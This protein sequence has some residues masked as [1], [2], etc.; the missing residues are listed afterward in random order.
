MSYVSYCIDFADSFR[1]L[2]VDQ[3]KWSQETF[4]TDAERGP[5]GALRHLEKEAVEAQEAVG[6]PKLQEELADCFLLLLDAN[7]RAG[8]RPW[9]LMK[10]AHAKMIINK[11]R[12]WPKP[13]DSETPVE[14]I[15]RR[16]EVLAELEAVER[17]RDEA[18]AVQWPWLNDGGSQ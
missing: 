18:A 5:M 8:F 9:D 4:G 10:A 7:R 17:E 11:T 12:T 13:T 14:H 3:S 2:V 16:G 15:H 1:E 6:T